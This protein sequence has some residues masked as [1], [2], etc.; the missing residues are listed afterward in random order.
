[1]SSYVESVL[2]P[3]ERIVHRAAV[4]HWNFALSYLLAALFFAAAVGALF[5]QS[6]RRTAIAIVTALIGLL[7]TVVALV[8]RATTELVLTDRR[9]I[10]KRGFIR[11]DTVEMNLGKVESL[12]VNQGLLGR[13]LNYGDVTVVGTGSSLEPLRGISGPLELRRKLGE[14]AAPAAGPGG[15]QP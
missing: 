10:A 12:H 7:T 3:G 13:M 6:E 15:S 9:V 5:L 4:S 2:A 14:I 8:R 11:R 1:M